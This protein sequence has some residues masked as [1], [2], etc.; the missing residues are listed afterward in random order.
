MF[1]LLID[2]KIDVSVEIFH[3]LSMIFDADHF[4]W[5]SVFQLF[6][7]CRFISLIIIW[8]RGKYFSRLLSLMLSFSLF[9]SF[10]YFDFRISCLFSGRYYF[11]S[12][13]IIFFLLFSIIIFLFISFHLFLDA[14]LAIILLLSSLPFHW[15][16]HYIFSLFIFFTF[17]IF[18]LFFFSYADIYW[19]EDAHYRAFDATLFSWN[20]SS[21]HFSDYFCITFLSFIIMTFSFI[22][23]RF[24]RSR[25][26]FDYA[27]YD[28]SSFDWCR[29]ISISLFQSWR[30]HATYFPLQVVCEA[31][32]FFDFSSI[33]DI[34]A[35]VASSMLFYYFDWLILFIFQ[36]AIFVF[37]QLFIFDHFS[38]VIYAFIFL[39]SDYFQ[40]HA[41]MPI[42]DYFR[43][44]RFS[45]IS[46]SSRCSSL[47]SSVSICFAASM[48]CRWLLLSMSFSL[49]MWCVFLSM[50]SR[51]LF[52]H[53]P[54]YRFLR[55]LLLLL[56]FFDFSL[57]FSQIFDFSIFFSADAADV[58][59]F[60]FWLFFWCG[61]IVLLFHWLIL[62]FRHYFQMMPLRFMFHFSRFSSLDSRDGAVFSMLSFIIF[63][64]FLS[65]LFSRWCSI[66]MLLISIFFSLRLM[67]I[68]LWPWYVLSLYY[69][70]A[71][72][73][74][75]LDSFSAIDTLLSFSR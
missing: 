29:L 63:D 75:S 69:F 3:W 56:R 42:F 47:L 50:I 58:V 7:W 53:K 8:C 35:D 17:L 67:L 22:L 26:R 4:D 30:L 19:C 2:V 14:F 71:D 37:L 48:W 6:W 73:S 5:F 65:W 40:L 59:I 9:F 62:I 28:A 36:I 54:G 15:V 21:F 12:F 20:I 27:L 46:F 68:S 44:F 60:H 52:R 38:Q 24:V 66:S 70:H 18:L 43:L 34:F 11:V 41:G 1:R 45:L 23:F 51:L 74:F 49:M 64:Y 31:F 61:L 55:F 72:V 25:L 33:E 32:D 16:F 13:H 57:I 39:F 10:D